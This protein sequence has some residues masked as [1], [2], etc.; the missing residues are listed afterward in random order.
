MSVHKRNSAQS[1]QPFGRLLATYIYIYT[2]VLFYYVDNEI[3]DDNTNYNDTRDH[4]ILRMIPLIIMI[5]G[6]S[7]T[8]FER[9]LRRLRSSRLR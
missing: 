7:L 2:N 3:S 6:M 1:V 8:W 5:L 9:E 4:D